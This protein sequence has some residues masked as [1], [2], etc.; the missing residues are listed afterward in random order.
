MHRRQFLSIGLLAAMICAGCF[1][2]TGWSENVSA[3]TAPDVRKMGRDTS[4]ADAIFAMQER[5]A[6]FPD[7]NDPVKVGTLLGRPLSRTGGATTNCA[8]RRVQL[9]EVWRSLARRNDPGPDD[10]HPLNGLL[11]HL[12]YG[13]DD[14]ACPGRSLSPPVLAEFMDV[15]SWACVMLADLKDRLSL[16]RIAWHGSASLIMQRIVIRPDGSTARLTISF[17]PGTWDACVDT[18]SVELPR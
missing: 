16:F 6:A 10:E 7:L 5:L 18:V 12:Q 17:R 11:F 9:T 13:K 4:S 2:A 8:G 15:Q 3:D 1:N 14:P